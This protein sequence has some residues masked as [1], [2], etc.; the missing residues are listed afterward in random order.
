METHDHLI[1]LAV[2]GEGE[3]AAAAARAIAE[4]PGM[5]LVAV[6]ASDAVVVADD[7]AARAIAIAR[8]ALAQ[9]KPA[10]CLAL[11]HDLAIL[12]DL[13]ALAADRGAPLSLPN[14]LR[15]L[16]ALVGLREAVARGETGP[17]LSLFAAWRTS[18]AIGEPLRALGPATLDLLHWLLPAPIDR[19]QV[20]AGMLFGPE[21]GAAACTLRGTDGIVRTVELA[22]ALPAQHDQADELLV[23]LLGEEAALRAEPFNLAITIIGTARRRQFWGTEALVPILDAFVAALRGDGDLPGDPAALR[24]SL[25][26][27]AALRAAADDGAARALP[28]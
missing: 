21:R 23:E 17:V 16:P 28:V 2:L 24:P 26:L 25:A 1:R 4:G 5:A 20:T 9:G 3:G 18:R 19:V 22:A 13:A 14:A 6:L 8:E 12:D 10:L 27:L 11:P 15:Y 7:D